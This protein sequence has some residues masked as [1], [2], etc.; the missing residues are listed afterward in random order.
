[1]RLLLAP[2]LLKSSSRPLFTVT[3]E[4]TGSGTVEA[5]LK[6]ARMSVPWLSVTPPVNTL[7]FDRFSAPRP[8][9]MMPEATLSLITPPRVAVMFSASTLI[10]VV[11]FSVSVPLSVRLLSPLKFRSVAPPASTRL[12]FTVNAPVEAR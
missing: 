8:V 7:L 9:L 5:P 10:V 1:M 3:A 2:P 12:L 11:P 4:P 6:P